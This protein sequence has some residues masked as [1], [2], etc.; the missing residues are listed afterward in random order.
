MS[1]SNILSS[2]EPVS[3]PRP[4]SPIP[5]DDTPAAT[6]KSEKPEKTVKAEKDKKQPRKSIKMSRVSD[7][8]SVESTPKIPRR[9][10]P[11]TP[12]STVR[13]PIKRAA[14]GIPKHRVFS[15]DKEKRIRDLMEQF[16]AEDV[17]ETDFEE[18]LRYWKQRAQRRR[19]EM[20]GRDVS[21]RQARRGDYAHVE[22]DKLQSHADFGKSRYF[23]VHYDE[24]LQ[25]VREQELFAEK[26]RKKDMQRK[27][28]REKSMATT[29]DQRAAALARASTAQDEAERLKYMREAERANKK[30]Q[31]TKY[32]LQKGLKGPARN[33]GP[34]EPNL[35]GGTMATFSAENMEPGKGKGKG[36]TGG[37][38]KKSKEQKQ[39]EKE[40]AEA[41]QAALD[42]G[43]ELPTREETA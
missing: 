20:N 30:V 27:R 11:E 36:R 4:T 29:M 25:E 8:R 41:A 18:E 19:Q 10:K 32:I 33:M 31:Q 42:A 26:E 12:S 5:V 40:S 39:A 7:I 17:D 16:D 35:E 28:R 23:E 14:N 22:A 34:M 37:R 6:R 13:I 43:E 15:A 1:F 9:P 38:L 24:A 3:K 2:S 21:L